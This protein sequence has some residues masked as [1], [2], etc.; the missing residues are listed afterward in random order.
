MGLSILW[1]GFGSQALAINDSLSV[2]VA[3]NFSKPAAEIAAAFEAQTGIKVSL[4]TGATGKF[5]AQIRHGA[6]FDVLLAADSLTIKKLIDDGLAEP[7]DHFTYAIGRIVLWS[8][9]PALFNNETTALRVLEA[10]N[11]N[12]IAMANPQVSP[13]GVAAQT[14]LAHLGLG[15]AWPGKRVQGQSIGQTYQFVASGNA[16]LGFVALSQIMDKTPQ[17]R[18]SDHA[19]G[20]ELTGSTWLAPQHW[21]SP[22]KQDAARLSTAQNPAHA[23]AFLAFLRSSEAQAV[24]TRYGYRL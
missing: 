11:F 23:K 3:A 16:T 2:A 15:Q 12:R 13:Y 5:Y 1:I 19:P 18:Q 24:I 20:V 17:T 6:P 9:D 21:Y 22:L 4:S 10:A 14:V 7:V 8:P